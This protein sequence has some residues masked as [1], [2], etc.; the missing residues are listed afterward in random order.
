MG[1]HV[2]T[3]HVFYAW[4]LDMEKRV[5][6]VKFGSGQSGCELGRVYLY[7]SNKFSLIF[8]CN[9]KK[10]KKNLFEKYG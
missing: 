8:F 5:G 7:F 4:E 9:W 3:T 6:Q 10:K 2:S 1:L